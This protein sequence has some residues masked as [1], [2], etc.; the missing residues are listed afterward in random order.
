MFE[1]LIFQVLSINP[2]TASASLELAGYAFRVTERAVYG[3]IPS[4][5]PW[6]ANARLLGSD[7][8]GIRKA[9]CISARMSWTWRPVLVQASSGLRAPLPSHKVSPQMAAHR[10][11]STT[12]ELYFLAA[13]SASLAA[14]RYPVLAREVS[15]MS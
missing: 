1:E 4:A 6:S 12:A 5:S 10:C 7:R 14:D 3:I 8:M 9:G 11:P 15:V 13:V 2:A